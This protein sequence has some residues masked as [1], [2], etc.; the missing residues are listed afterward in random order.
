MQDLRETWARQPQE[1][2]EGAREDEERVDRVNI[3]MVMEKWMDDACLSAIESVHDMSELKPLDL[4]VSVL[5]TQ[6]PTEDEGGGEHC[7]NKI[8]A[9]L[10]PEQ[11]VVYTFQQ[12]IAPL[13][14]RRCQ[15]CLS[16]VRE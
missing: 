10:F 16:Q 8:R 11:L 12:H 15:P 6:D 7:R 1:A 2:E 5:F 13:S 4:L 9:G 14:S 3:A